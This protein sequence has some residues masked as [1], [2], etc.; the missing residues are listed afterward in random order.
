MAIATIN[1]DA[2]Y[3]T[4]CDSVLNEMLHGC[5]PDDEFVVA[6]MTKSVN[7]AVT[8]AWHDGLSHDGWCDA[9]LRRLRR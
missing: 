6:E 2:A 5:D 7:D 8:N 1:W 3:E 4:A 9:A